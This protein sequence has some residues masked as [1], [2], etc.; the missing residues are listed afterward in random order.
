MPSDWALLDTTK[1]WA[2]W[3]ALPLPERLDTPDLLGFVPGDGSGP[4]KGVICD[5]SLSSVHSLRRQRKCSPHLSADFYW[6][7]LNTHQSSMSP[8]AL[9]PPQA[10]LFPEHT[11]IYIFLL[12]ISSF[13]QTKET[14]YSE[15]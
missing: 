1:A 2:V 12:F 10:M 15:G 11:P 13:Q 14:K 4:N 3:L 6:R 5:D 8:P 7:V 9:H